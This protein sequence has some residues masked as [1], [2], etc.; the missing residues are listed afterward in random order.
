M[1]LLRIAQLCAV[2]LM[3]LGCRGLPRSAPECPQPT[4]PSANGCER[5]PAVQ[6]LAQRSTS[7]PSTPTPPVP[8]AS[9]VSLTSANAP[10]PEV[11][12]TPDGNVSSDDPLVVD[13]E[14]DLSELLDGVLARNP[15]L[16]TMIAAWRAA[17]E[18]YP[19]AISLE[20]PMFNSAIGPA[21]FGVQGRAPGYMGGASQKIPGF[22]KRPLRGQK[23]WAEAGAASLD[24]GDVR[25]RL[26]EAT[27]TTYYEYYLAFRQS[28]LNAENIRALRAFRDDAEERYRANLVTQQ[29]VLQADVELALLD[30][31]QVELD[32]NR[33]V[34]IARINT[35]LDRAPDYP[36][37]PPP[38]A[39][40]T[41]EASPPADEL[42][43]TAI[44]NRPDLGAIA[45]RLRAEQSALALANKDYLP[46]FEVMGRYDAF[47]QEPQLR[48]MVGL[49]ANVPIYR[50]RLNAAVREAM[51]RIS[52][53]RA[54]YRQRVDDINREVQTAWEQLEAAKD[55]VQLYQRR[56]VPTARQNVESARAGYLSGR[57]D[58]LRL[59]EAERQLIFLLQEQ[60]DLVA[61]YHILRAEL[62]RAVAAPLPSQNGPELGPEER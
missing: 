52:Q 26:V 56:I 32:R 3:V 34:A 61:Q 24:V 54:E 30:R 40:P 22:G 15:S 33:D 38:A 37:P 12:D 14:L 45:A 58:F 59:I 10:L 18:K 41:V 28:D 29:D 50:D 25:L 35:L 20:D 62:E 53:R 11:V 13:G 27:R 21:S 49:N 44:A 1:P 4:A 16:Q 46:D 36:L 47:W 6:P 43:L 51:F 8:Q 48:A 9:R 17:S 19:Q 31:R 55:L 7:P 5:T 42:R 39:L 23:A 2:S 60:E 57:V